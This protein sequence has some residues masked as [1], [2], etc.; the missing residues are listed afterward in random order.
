MYALYFKYTPF[1]KYVWFGVSDFLDIEYYD[2]SVP[3]CETV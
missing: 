3:E 2:Y 1:K